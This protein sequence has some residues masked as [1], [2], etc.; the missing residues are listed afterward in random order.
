[1]K[2]YCQDVLTWISD[3]Q[4]S[5]VANTDQKM[6]LILSDFPEY[7]QKEN[8]NRVKIKEKLVT[9]EKINSTI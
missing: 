4:Y 1:M 6:E 3:M 2:E 9:T 8:S 5:T 7:Q